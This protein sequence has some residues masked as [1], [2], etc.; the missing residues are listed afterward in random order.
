MLV[1]GS[2]EIGAEKTNASKAS[3]KESLFVRLQSSEKVFGEAAFIKDAVLATPNKKQSFYIFDPFRG[4]I[5]YDQ[6]AKAA[7]RI[8][9]SH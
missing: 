7:G 3:K 9:N 1:V 8:P 4:L 6:K 2:P 5:V